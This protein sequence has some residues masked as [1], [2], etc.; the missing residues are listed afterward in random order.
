VSES[1]TESLSDGPAQRSIQALRL[2]P[3]AARIPPMEPSTYASFR[4]DIAENGLREPL[5]VTD[6]GVVLDGRERLRAAQD[7]GIAEVPVRV[8]AP[9]DQVVYRYRC[10]LL[11]R[12]LDPSRRAALALELVEYQ[13]L[14]AAGRARSRKNLRQE[15]IVEVATSPSRERTRDQLAAV[16][17]VSTRTIQD[18]ITVREH[19]LALFKM[20]RE[21]EIPV[22]RAARRVRRA[23]LRENAETPPPLPEGKYDL[24]Y[25][26]PP[27]QMQT[28]DIA[29]G[30]ED[31]YPTMTLAQIKALPIPA[32]DRAVLFL[33]RVSSLAREAFGVLDAWRFD[34]HAEVVWVKPSIGP[35][36]WVR[37]RHEVL[38]IATRGGHPT[39]TPTGRPDSVV[40]APRGRHSEKP[41]VFYEL[42]ER[43]YPNAT[44]LELFARGKPR[45]G[46]TVWGNEAGN[47]LDNRA[48]HRSNG[49]PVPAV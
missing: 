31:H 41:K 42:I 6:A 40:E 46:W 39:P 33:W 7:L 12:H 2:H 49:V 36:C 10:A 8:V 26:D 11:R 27:W 21:G 14:L 13:Q 29:S 5:H 48:D 44:R 19:D 28:L 9:R 43:A 32:A 37:H 15:T 20:V 34:Y 22:H 30:P 3:E 25:A 23:Q 18:A 47:P 45:Q 35:G 17:G 1:T 16:A 4:A 38:L 24:I